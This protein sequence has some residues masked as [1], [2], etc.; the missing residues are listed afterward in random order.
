MPRRWRWL[1]PIATLIA[2]VYP[3]AGASAAPHVEAD[4]QASSLVE[5]RAA[6]HAQIATLWALTKR[7]QEHAREP[8]GKATRV[9]R[10]AVAQ[11]GD[12]Y[13]YGGPGPGAF[14]CSGLT[15]FGFA[16]AGVKL[17]HSSYGQFAAGT[18]VGRREI[19]RGDLVFF[20]T[21]GSGAS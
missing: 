14:D 10:T 6:E 4:F 3:R 5:R 16:E 12:G 18:A 19:R 17:P 11:I 20:S 21:A 7:K 9:V 2:C 8:A 13:A 1:V 15:A